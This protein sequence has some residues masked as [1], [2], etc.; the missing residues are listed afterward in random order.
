MNWNIELQKVNLME[1]LT[2]S[3]KNGADLMEINVFSMESP[4]NYKDEEIEKKNIDA[5]YKDL[6]QGGKYAYVNF[7]SNAMDEELS[8]IDGN[9]YLYI[10]EDEVEEYFEDEEIPMDFQPA[11]KLKLYEDSSVGYLLKC[12]KENLQIQSAIIYVTDST[13]QVQDDVEL[14]NQPMES[15]I[16]KFLDNEA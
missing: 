8:C 14:L 7:S 2:A 4:N 9:T 16:S 6:I 11:H 12:D 5:I 13:I 10:Q 1:F 3:N 15:Y